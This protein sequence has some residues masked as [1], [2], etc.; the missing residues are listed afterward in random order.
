MKQQSAN[1][2]QVFDLT[3]LAERW[4][5]ELFNAFVNNQP[6]ALDYITFDVRAFIS[7]VIMYVY[8]YQRKRQWGNITI[9][10]SHIVRYEDRSIRK[11]RNHKFQSTIRN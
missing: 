9:H 7:H 5:R 2:N 1:E 10:T 4:F 3:P 8:E 6:E 11:I